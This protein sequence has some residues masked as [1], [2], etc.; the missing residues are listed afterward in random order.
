MEIEALRLIVLLSE[1]LNFTQASDISFM[2]Q[3]T[4]SRKIS[5]IEN[6][7][8]I[9]MFS[10]T[11]HDVS[12]TAEGELIL[13]EIRKLIS[14]YDSVVSR[15]REL[16]KRGL[17][18]LRIAY[19]VYPYGLGFCMK[20]EKILSDEHSH[21]SASLSFVSFEDSER[22]LLEGDIDG[23]VSVDGI[24][25]RAEIGKI[26]LSPSKVYAVINTDDRLSECE[27]I[28]LE[29]L[30]GRK[31]ILSGRRIMPSLFA[32]RKEYFEGKGIAHASIIEAD[33]AKEAMMMASRGEGIPILN[34]EGHINTI[35]TLR[36][37]PFI[38]DMPELD[39]IFFWD[40]RHE[41][42]QLREYIRAVI[43]ASEASDK[44]G[45]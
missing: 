26:K 32:A 44:E 14:H 1:T 8:G 30:G 13:P 24:P 11:T 9:K 18:P 15:C 19:T 45:L 3:S 39:F 7:L 28:S 16:G 27:S 17:I 40:K 12:I 29:D 41:T 43:A 23:L 22:A 37:V 4:F 6:E 21:V 33:S 38:S 31:I 2:S 42:E 20:T 10:R 5:Q 34:E 36:P 25:D 35:D